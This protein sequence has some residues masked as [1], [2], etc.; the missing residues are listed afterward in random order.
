[1]SALSDAHICY[2]AS[3]MPVNCGAYN[4]YAFGSVR[5]MDEPVIFGSNGN[6][7]LE[8]TDMLSQDSGKFVSWSITYYGRP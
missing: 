6:W 8:V 1:M 5:H 2:N 7:T 4:D 3:E